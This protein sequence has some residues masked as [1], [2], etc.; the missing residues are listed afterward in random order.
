MGIVSLIPHYRKTMREALLIFN[1]QIK[2]MK[3]GFHS[4]QQQELQV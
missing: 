1:R 2:I 3:E 4:E